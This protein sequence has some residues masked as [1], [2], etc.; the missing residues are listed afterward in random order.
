MAV[1]VDDDEEAEAAM[2]GT[3]TWS[4][5]ALADGATPHHGIL[6][7]VLGTYPPRNS[8]STNTCVASGRSAAT[9]LA[10][11]AIMAHWDNRCVMW[12]TAPNSSK[13][14]G[15]YHSAGAAGVE[16]LGA[17]G[18]SSAPPCFPLAF[19]AV[20][21]LAVADVDTTALVLAVLLLNTFSGGSGAS[22][23]SRWPK[24]SHGRTHL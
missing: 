7:D 8:V 4:F 11:H 23:D 21:F 20:C 15:V 24:A 16:P 1:V 12:S 9:T 19:L 13:F 2:G 14:G 10:T 6:S 22:D 18:V 5:L 3:V 17:A